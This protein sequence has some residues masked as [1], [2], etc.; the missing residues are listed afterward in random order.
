MLEYGTPIAFFSCELITRS[1]LRSEVSLLAAGL[2][3]TIRS[4]SITRGFTSSLVGIDDSFVSV[5]C[6]NV[7]LLATTG[8]EQRSFMGRSRENSCA[9]RRRRISTG[10]FEFT[11]RC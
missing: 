3:V 7:V 9:D 5:G 1:L 2:C 4:F 6:G 8:T 11:F 10:Q